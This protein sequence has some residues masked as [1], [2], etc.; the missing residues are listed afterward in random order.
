[1]SVVWHRRQIKQ[2]IKKIIEIRLSLALKIGFSLKEEKIAHRPQQIM[3][4]I[5][6]VSW[7]RFWAHLCKIIIDYEAMCPQL[8]R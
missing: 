6:L 8:M 2:T 1:M 4:T 7:Q 3:L 5:V